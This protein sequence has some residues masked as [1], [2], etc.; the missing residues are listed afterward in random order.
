MFFMLCV[1]FFLM[2]R[3]PP[4]STRTDTL[5]P[6]TTLF[7]S[8]ASLPG[9][10]HVSLPGRS[11]HRDVG[12]PVHGLSDQDLQVRW[13]SRAAVDAHHRLES[14]LLHDLRSRRRQCRFLKSGRSEER[15]VGKRCVRTSS[16]RWWLDLC[17]NKKNKKQK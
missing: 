16:T 15:R 9:R 7:R 1:F 12:T 4:R 17:K 8:A 10:A 2:I 5:F 6:Y 11:R 13:L 3:R 14:Q